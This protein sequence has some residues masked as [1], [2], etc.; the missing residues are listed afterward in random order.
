[1]TDAAVEKHVPVY[2]VEGS[3]VH[4]VVGETTCDGKKKMYELMGECKNVYV[5]S[6]KATIE[7]DLSLFEQLKKY[8]KS[9]GR[10]ITEVVEKQLKSLLGTEV[11][12][13]PVSSKL[14]GIVNLP[15]NFDYKEELKN[16]SLEK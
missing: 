11:K 3:H 9:K 14:R 12:D 1:M 5:M 16:R 13:K 6:T 4:V 15:E 2:T 7:V 8:A 10:T